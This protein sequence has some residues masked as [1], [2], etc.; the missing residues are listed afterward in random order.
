[1]RIRAT[2]GLLPKIMRWDYAF[3]IHVGQ[4]MTTTSTGEF[5]PTAF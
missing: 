5:F 4:K 3:S 1:M 2:P